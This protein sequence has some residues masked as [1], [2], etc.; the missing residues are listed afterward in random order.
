MQI[1]AAGEN[2]LIVY[3]GEKT[4]PEV[5][6]HVHGDTMELVQALRGILAL[7]SGD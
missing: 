2:A 7:V 5:S 4:S 3:L 1:H 6:A